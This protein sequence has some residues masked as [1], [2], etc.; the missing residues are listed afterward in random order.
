MYI[1]V[2]MRMVRTYLHW[3]LIKCIHVG[4][5]CSKRKEK[6][7]DNE[8]D[9]D[10]DDDDR[11]QRSENVHT[12]LNYGNRTH[13]H[14]YRHISTFLIYLLLL[15][16]RSVVYVLYSSFLYFMHTMKFRYTCA[17]CMLR[18]FVHVCTQLISSVRY[19]QI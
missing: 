5:I 8:N 13:I 6:S 14:R 18:T 7:N 9:V 15:C 4:G 2:Y 16:T 17:V 19:S 10:D 12:K 11:T 3:A 1:C